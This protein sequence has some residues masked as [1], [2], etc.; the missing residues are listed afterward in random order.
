MDNKLEHLKMFLPTRVNLS[1]ALK[2]KP[3][4]PP[5]LADDDV[6]AIQSQLLGAFRQSSD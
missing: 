2:I 5:I 6:T 3:P 4:P 1:F